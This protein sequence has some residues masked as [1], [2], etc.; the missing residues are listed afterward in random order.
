MV[1]SVVIGWPAF[2]QSM[3]RV[4]QRAAK[5]LRSKIYG[6]SRTGE[7]LQRRIAMPRT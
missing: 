3:R 6:A 1:L 7:T 4:A 2:M 5:P